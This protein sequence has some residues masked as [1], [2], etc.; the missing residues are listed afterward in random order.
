VQIGGHPDLD[1]DLPP[2][3]IGS[4]YMKI[5]VASGQ[6]VSIGSARQIRDKGLCIS[7]GHRPFL[8][9]VEYGTNLILTHEILLNIHFQGGE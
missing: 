8:V 5:V 6:V 2:I 3:Q 7:I 1:L 4:A 9:E